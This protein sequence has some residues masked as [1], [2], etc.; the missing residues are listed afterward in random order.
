MTTERPKSGYTNSLIDIRPGAL[1]EIIYP[2]ID[3]GQIT[4]FDPDQPGTKVVGY[5]ICNWPSDPNEI[6]TSFLFRQED[7]FLFF[8]SREIKTEKR[9]PG[10]N[11]W[12]AWNQKEA[13]YYPEKEAEAVYRPL[14]VKYLANSGNLGRLTSI[15]IGPL[16]GEDHYNEHGGGSFSENRDHLT[17]EETIK[18]GFPFGT[19]L[20]VVEDPPGILKLKHPKTKN[21]S[22]SLQQALTIYPNGNQVEIAGK[23]QELWRLAFDFQLRLPLDLERKS[24]AD[25]SLDH[26]AD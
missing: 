3:L 21:L 24:F 11:L 10:F 22:Y 26:Q 8:R 7:R 16:P 13:L 9:K 19:R 4:G 1:R 17:A 25:W 14:A 20:E 23:R 6:D 2:G 12:L 15:W 18:Q 5:G